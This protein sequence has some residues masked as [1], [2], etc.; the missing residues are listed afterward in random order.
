[1]NHQLSLFFVVCT[2][3]I[4]A[5]L[6]CCIVRLDEIRNRS[7]PSKSVWRIVRVVSLTW[8]KFISLSFFIQESFQKIQ[9][10]EVWNQEK[11]GSYF[12]HH[13]SFQVLSFKYLKCPIRNFSQTKVPHQK[14]HSYSLHSM[15][16]IM[17]SPKNL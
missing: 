1:M 7:L 2:K 13:L 17:N 15:D 3:L 8:P 12:Q 4:R 16:M 14:Q 5:N 11:L 9:S 10:I 6:L